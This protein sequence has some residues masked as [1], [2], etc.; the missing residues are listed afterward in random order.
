MA[1]RQL[2]PMEKCVK[3]HINSN[4]GSPAFETN[5]AY[6]AGTV[7]T[8]DNKIFVSIK[9]LTASHVGIS[10]PMDAPEDWGLVTGQSF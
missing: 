4:D 7:V 6:E 1:T 8:D 9:D 5:T 2:I 10:V 3:A